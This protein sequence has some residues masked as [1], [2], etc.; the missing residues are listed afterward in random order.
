MDIKM[1]NEPPEEVDLATL[2]SPPKSP[3]KESSASA[4]PPPAR[5]G[6]QLIPHFP[7]AEKEALK[8]FVNLTDNTY[9]YARL[10]QTKAQD[11]GYLCECEYKHG[12]SDPD[13]ACGESADCINRLTQVECVEGECRCRGHCRNQR[14]QQKQYSPID[15]VDTGPKGFG[16]RARENLPKDAF[17]FEYIGEVVAHTSFM[18]RMRDYAREGL[19]HFYFMMLQKD[20]YIDA[21]KK[22]CIARFANHSCNPNCYVAKWTVGPRLRMGI[23]AKR[24]ILKD[25]ELTFNYNVDRYGHEA[26]KC[27]CGEPNCVGYIGGNKQT[28]MATVDDMYLDALGITEA[29]VEATRKKKKGKRITNIDDYAAELKP[30]KTPEVPKVI[31]AMRQTQNR[32]VLLKV[33]I[34]M[35]ITEDEQPLRMVMRLRGFSLLKALYMEY[36]AD[37][38]MIITAMEAMLKWPLINR[39]KVDNS[40]IEEEVRKFLDSE[41]ERVKA[42]AQELLDHWAKF[43]VVYKIPKRLTEET[44]ET[45]ETTEEGKKEYQEVT[46]SDL[47]TRVNE[48]ATVQQTLAGFSLSLP[49]FV[50]PPPIPI[51][52]V[53]ETPASPLI[54]KPSTRSQIEEI[55]AAATKAAAL[56]ESPGGDNASSSRGGSRGGSQ[57]TEDRKKSRED[58]DK[59]KMSREEKE[60]AREKRLSK[61]IAPVVVKSMSRHKKDFKHSDDFKAQAKKLVAVIVEKEKKSSSYATSKLES[62]EDHKKAKI[63]KFTHQWVTKYIKKRASH[64]HS[65]SKP[66]P[67]M[68]RTPPL[69]EDDDE[70]AMDVDGMED[71]KY[72]DVAMDDDT[73]GMDDE[74]AGGSA[75][76][77]GDP[78]PS[79]RTLVEVQ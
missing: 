61:L 21:T 55:I 73:L 48:G 44:T 39:N 43:S 75:S 58:R 68:A 72:D 25:E 60:A 9:Q 64:S 79:E 6:P 57:G 24:K 22:G 71:E 37:H 2:P 63:S 4:T 66:Q 76:P 52:K 50:L 32:K 26:Q 10:G 62:L 78:P 65:H 28:E 59:K 54:T 8:T 19:K 41:N 38:E 31:Q 30:L 74:D 7:V 56:K 12:V 20:E 11:E 3:R 16:L 29:D 34:R 17:I 18:K 35:R 36:G 45:T 5:T 46:L 49:S 13:E 47:L 77:A 1:D 40:N 14:F 53:T 51:R 42:L 15:V 23:F 27:Y 70:T 69:D 33:L 67:D